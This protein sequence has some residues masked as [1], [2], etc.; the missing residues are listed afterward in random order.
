MDHGGTTR[1]GPALS[2]KV[3]AALTTLAA[4]EKLAGD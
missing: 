3:H 1:F 4:D 2:R